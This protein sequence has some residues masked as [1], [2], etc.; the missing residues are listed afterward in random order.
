MDKENDKARAVELSFRKSAGGLSS[1]EE[2][3]LKRLREMNAM[4][5]RASNLSPSEKA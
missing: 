1:S 3:E 2:E 4:K 5:R